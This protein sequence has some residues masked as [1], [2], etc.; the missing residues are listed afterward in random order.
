MFEQSHAKFE[1]PQPVWNNDFDADKSTDYK[2]QFNSGAALR[3]ASHQLADA[4]TIGRLE[5]FDS[6]NNFWN[7]GNLGDDISMKHD[8]KAPLSNGSELFKDSVK[9]GMTV[10]NLSS[11]EVEVQPTKVFCPPESETPHDVKPPLPFPQSQNADDVIRSKNDNTPDASVPPVQSP[12]ESI[13]AYVPQ[14]NSKV[15][16]PPATKPREP[17]FL[18]PSIPSIFTR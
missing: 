1:A 17:I 2:S 16:I 6:T 4:G 12:K 14:D 7:P 15:E 9:L 18:L 5:L 10:K 11:G 13:P 8:D 3:A